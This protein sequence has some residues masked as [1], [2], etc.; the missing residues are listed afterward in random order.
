MDKEHVV[1]LENGILLRNL[2]KIITSEEKWQE[3]GKNHP[4][5]T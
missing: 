3:L 1:H 2:K 5:Q 4:M